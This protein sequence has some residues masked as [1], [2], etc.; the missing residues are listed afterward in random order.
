MIYRKWSLLTGPVSI[1]GGIV[2]ATMVAHLIFLDDPYLKPKK[3][4]IDRV[5]RS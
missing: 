3:K 5:E 4:T 2:G 1:L